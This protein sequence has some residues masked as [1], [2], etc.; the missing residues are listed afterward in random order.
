MNVTA[1]IA[2]KTQS[3]PSST[4]VSNNIKFDLADKFGGPYTQSITVALPVKT[5]TF[6]G[7]PD[8]GYVIHA[9]RLSATEPP[10]GV[11]QMAESF[12]DVVNPIDIEVPDTISVT[13][14]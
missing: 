14:G 13:L 11:G 6:T 9:Q 4:S 1:T 3:V 5:V 12:V 7:V 8:G 2:T 10:V